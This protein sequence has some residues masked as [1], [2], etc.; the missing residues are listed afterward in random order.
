M[1]ELGCIP[2]PADAVFRPDP[3]GP[4]A[5][6][7]GLLLGYFGTPASGKDTDVFNLTHV[8]VVNLDYRNEADT[9][10]I[11]PEKLETFDAAA[12]QWCAAGSKRITLHLPPGGGK[13]LRVRP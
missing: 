2:L 10:L 5:T 7:R 9:S 6:A 13:L 4:Q 8:M 3:A 11:G 12:R 1:R